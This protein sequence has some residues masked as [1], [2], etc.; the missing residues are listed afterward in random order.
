MNYK[1]AEVVNIQFYEEDG[2]IYCRTLSR[3]RKDETPPEK[4]DDCPQQEIISL[5]HA[6]L[7]ECPK[8]R[9]WT[10][11]CKAQLRARWRED[12]K[13]QSL[14]FWQE[15]FEYIRES[16]FLM[17]KKAPSANFRRFIVTL[18]WIVTADK[19]SKLIEGNYHRDN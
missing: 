13:R 19:F 17:G 11:R 2:Y 18:R 12:K 14:H 3:F 5:F 7:P 4:I 6:I 10:D 8:V 15:L 16:D 9:I 1:T